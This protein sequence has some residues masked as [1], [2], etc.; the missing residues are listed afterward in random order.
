MNITPA[1]YNS[2]KAINKH[3]QNDYKK[4]YNTKTAFEVL[5]LE[6]VSAVILDGNTFWFEYPSYSNITNKQ[7]EALK[8][9]IKKTRKYV[10]LYDKPI[11]RKLRA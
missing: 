1:I 8:N 11:E 9:Y 3:L 2:L 5:D 6:L 10:W 7:I 4:T